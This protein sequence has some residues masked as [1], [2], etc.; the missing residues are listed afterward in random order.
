MEE[1]NQIEIPKT[2]PQQIETDGCYK[3][4]LFLMVTCFLVLI[5]TIAC[6]DGNS[7]G[8]RSK[9]GDFDRDVSDID[10]ATKYLKWKINQERNK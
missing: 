5:M 6:G 9:P 10:K 1:N 3:G 2:S 7:W 4:C 8:S